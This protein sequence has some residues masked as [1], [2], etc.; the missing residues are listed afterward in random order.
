MLF[1]AEIFSQKG[2][3]RRRLIS[4]A[5]AQFDIKLD[6]ELF[7]LLFALKYKLQLVNKIIKKMT[8]LSN[9]QCLIDFYRQNLEAI[10][11]ENS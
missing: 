3:C 1:F 10:P 7:S 4:I 6:I 11:I 9:F 8:E 5:N 2:V